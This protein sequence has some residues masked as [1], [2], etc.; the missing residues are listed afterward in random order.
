MMILQFC[1]EFYHCKMTISKPVRDMGR[2]TMIL[3]GFA[4]INSTGW[5]TM[6]YT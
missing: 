5:F 2:G 1:K 3:L 4:H 6:V